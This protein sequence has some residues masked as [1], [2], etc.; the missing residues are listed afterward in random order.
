MT[1]LHLWNSM[2]LN[3]LI[4]HLCQSTAFAGLVWLLTIALRNYPARTRFSVWMAAS[5]KFLVPFALLT[6]LGSYWA[7]PNSRLPMYGT[8]TR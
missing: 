1:T 4:S 5:I 2:T 6:A 3:A 7:L 8:S